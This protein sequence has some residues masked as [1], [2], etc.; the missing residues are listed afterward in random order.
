[1][2][3]FLPGRFLVSRAFTRYTSKPCCSNTPDIGIQ[4]AP[5]DC[6]TAVLIRLPS[7][8]PPAGADRLGSPI[9][10]HR[11]VMFPASGVDPRRVPMHH[12]Q[13]RTAGPDLPPQFFPLLACQPLFDSVAVSHA[14]TFLHPYVVNSSEARHGRDSV[15]RGQAASFKAAA[16]TL[17]ID[18]TGA[19]LLYE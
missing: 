17:M 14:I 15:E 2:P 18:R 12:V 10:P 13:P 19:R 4:H 9:R 16:T 8:I 11:H 1:M 6:I 3:I 7:T 5:V